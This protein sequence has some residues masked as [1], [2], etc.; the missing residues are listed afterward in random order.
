DVG[1]GAATGAAAGFTVDLMTGGLSLGAGTLAGAAAGGL[2]QGA[3]RYGK[4]LL[5]RLRGY[6]ELSLNDQVLRLLA[7]RQL[8][9][10]AALEQRGHAATEPIQINISD[11]AIVQNKQLPE[12]LIEARA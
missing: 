3:E 8:T 6:R 4:R 10:I 5:G 1:L 9:L 12:A 11:R 2:W 7:A